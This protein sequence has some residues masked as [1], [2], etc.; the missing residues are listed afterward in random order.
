M[1]NKKNKEEIQSSSVEL[2]IRLVLQQLG[3]DKTKLPQELSLALEKRQPP[4]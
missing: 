1:V 4:Q 3:I 2:D